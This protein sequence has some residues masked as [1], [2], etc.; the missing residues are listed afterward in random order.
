VNPTLLLRWALRESRGA[1]GRLA[2][3][4]ACLALGVAAVVAVTGAVDSLQQGMAG[5]TRDLLGADLVVENRAPFPP[6]L[7]ALLAEAVPDARRTDVI[8]M[9]SMAAAPGVGD[10]LGRSSLVELKVLDGPFPFYGEVTLDPPGAL[11]EVLD[12]GSAA[13]AP[14]L[15]SALGLAPGDDVLIGGALFTVVAQVMAEPDRLGISFTLGPRVFIDQAGFERTDLG[16]FGNRVE[17]K[18]MLAVT[19]DVDVRAVESRLRSELERPGLVRDVDS[20]ADSQPGVSRQ[21]ERVERTL[22]LMALLSL[23][24]GGIGVSQVVRAWLGART[25]S[26]AVMRCLGMRPAEILVMFLGQVVVL[27]SVGCVLGAAA[28]AIVPWLLPSLL[29]D[30]VPA[31]LVHAFQP[32]AWLRGI[33]LGLGLAL[34]F[35][36]PPLTAIWRVAPAKVLRAEAAPL[37][38]PRSVSV[39]CFLALLLGVF[40]SA[41]A[42]G[43]RPDLA[44][45]FTLG[46]AV[47]ALVLTGAA[48]GVMWAVGRLPREKVGPTFRHGLAALARPGAGT[49]GAVTALGLGVFVVLS[50]AVVAERLSHSL[51]TALPADAPT[52][53]LVDVQPD[54]WEPLSA[55]LEARAPGSVRSTPVVMARLAEIDGV[56]VADLIGSYGRDRDRGEEARSGDSQSGEGGGPRADGD[57][58][59]GRGD[60]RGRWVLTR[61]QRLTW[62]EELG[63]DNQIIEGELW[64]RP[65]VDEVS[66][67]EGFAESLGAEV[68]TELVFDVQGVPVPL[69]VTSIRTVEWRSFAINFFLVAE[70]GVLDDAPHF[71]I[72][73]TRLTPEAQREVQDVVAARFPNVTLMDVRAILEKVAELLTMLATGIG[74]LGLLTVITGLAVLAGSVAS[75]SLRRGREAALLKTL[76]VTRQGVVRLF[77]IE[78]ALLGAVAGT[79]GG[80]AG[81]LLA[82]GFLSE[83]A[84]LAVDMP[85]V[86][87]PLAAVLAAVLSAVCGIAACRGALR[88]PPLLSLRG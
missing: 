10:D 78:H 46:L 51:R 58:R 9:R 69:T 57:Q 64:S 60:G 6:E 67:E 63:E 61:E 30:V 16:A 3:L 54:Q 62:M 73:T 80:V 71:R 21:L 2:A 18:A 74:A 81:M 86:A 56:S 79:V 28:G 41:W 29:P 17:Y 50:V 23:V 75:T 42:L 87:V 76:G 34:V 45:W 26:V 52:A 35:A 84:E 20:G 68:G 55:E 40:G 59:A 7:D 1:R 11:H 88:Q 66:L 14:S 77:A 12:E 65:G 22:G 38:A 5:K 39:F 85:W 72:A 43:D 4:T 36:L 83:V 82:S 31:D 70:P 47:A 8:E 27:A 13:V 33:G 53:F 32:M 37:P 15:L 25:A 49:T 19:P 44:G 48:R 24:L